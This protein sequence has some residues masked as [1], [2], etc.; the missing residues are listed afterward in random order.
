M[1]DAPAA[2]NEVAIKK[3]VALR[4]DPKQDIAPVLVAK[5]QG[6]VAERILALPVPAANFRRLTAGE[7]GQLF[8]LEA[9]A[10][11]RPGAGGGS[12]HK[13]DFKTRKDEV[14]LSNVAQYELSADKKKV[15]YTSGGAFFLT[16]LAPKPQPGQGRLNIDA[17]EVKINPAA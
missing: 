7:A 10:G 16:A 6:Y 5:G 1:T 15:F 12:L 14:I 3:T 9:P 13:F 4:Y 17:I 11:F 2:G 8:Y